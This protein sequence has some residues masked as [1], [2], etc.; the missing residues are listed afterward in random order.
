MVQEQLRSIVRLT[1]PE[2]ATG[3]NDDAY[4]RL[5]DIGI[6]VQRDGSLSINNDRFEVAAVNPSRLQT[7]FANGGTDEDAHGFARR[8]DTLVTNLLSVDGAVTGAT[9]TLRRREDLIEDQQARL[10]RRLVDIEERLVRQYTN[11]DANLA[12]LS[13][14]LQT[15]SGL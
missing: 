11:L 14:A 15:V 13:S 10:E 4:S 2:A 9:D 7:L 8:F 1:L 5:S 3:E 6:E 12:R